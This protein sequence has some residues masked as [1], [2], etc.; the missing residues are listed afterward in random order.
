MG[1]G[2]S[3]SG[4]EEMLVQWGQDYRL[5]YQELLGHQSKNVLYDLIRFRG[6][7]PITTGY[8]PE[9]VN[10]KSDSVERLVMKLYAVN[11]KAATCIRLLYCGR[12]P[13]STKAEMASEALGCSVSKA[14]FKTMVRMAQMYLLGTLNA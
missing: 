7:I 9:P 14:T 6:R 3:E 5:D 11:P 4:L 13:V 2:I 8:K 12:G 10:T 1:Q